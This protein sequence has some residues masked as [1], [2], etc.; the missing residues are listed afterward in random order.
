MSQVAGHVSEFSSCERVIRGLRQ[1]IMKGHDVEV[2]GS[3]DPKAV[4]RL[5]C[6][7]PEVFLPGRPDESSGSYQSQIH[8][9]D[10]IPLSP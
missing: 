3:S 7:L 9:N 6:G 2:L 5:P 1:L 4:L 8:G 10:A